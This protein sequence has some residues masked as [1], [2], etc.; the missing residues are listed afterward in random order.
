MRSAVVVGTGLIGTS[1]ALA[2]T[3]R[4]VTVH[5]MD[6]DPAAAHAAASLGAGIAGEP[7]TRVDIA[8]IAV[9]PAAVAPVLADLQRRAIARVHTDAASVKTLPSRQIEVLGCDSSSHVGGHPL[10]GSERSGPY[11]ARG[12]LFEGRPWVLVPEPR[13]SAA[14]L[15]G[16]HAVVSA[17][18]ATPVLMGAEEHDRAMALVSHVP[19]L[20][21]GLLA[22]RLL[23]GDP[24]AL[25]VAG[26]GV[27]DTT[28]IA[29]GRPALWTEI[30]A[31]NAGNV[32]DVLDGMAAD[33]AATVSALRALEAAP[34]QADALAE[35]TGMLQR[36][37]DGRDRV[38][39]GS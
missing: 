1:V 22:G 13:S 15:D 32:A 21:A 26:Q 36:G 9:P 35:L 5:L 3:G 28:R 16:A 19:H 20:V 25:G 29:G 34:R 6:H 17:C 2:L 27:R 7:R 30:L 4:G 18:G 39:A 31:A 12:S 37:V 33:L 11:A 8:V 38:G 23:D 24:A 10:A 14:A